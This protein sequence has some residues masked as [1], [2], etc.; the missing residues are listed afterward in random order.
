MTLIREFLA[1]SDFLVFPQI[2]L[3][4]FFSV[5]VAVLVRVLRANRGSA[6]F[7]RLS[8]MPLDDN[9]GSGLRDE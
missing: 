3:V 9:E 1:G 8:R 2:A 6:A 7:E 4:L 5:F